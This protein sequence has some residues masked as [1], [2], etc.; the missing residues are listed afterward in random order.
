[1]TSR[2]KWVKNPPERARPHPTHYDEIVDDLKKRPGE[3]A[4]ISRIAKEGL[5]GSYVIPGYAA[6]KRRGCDVFQRTVGDMLVLYA[7]WPVQKAS[8]GTERKKG[9]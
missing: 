7:T 3:T 9:R 4:E 6:L 5:S 2:I 8:A 1:M